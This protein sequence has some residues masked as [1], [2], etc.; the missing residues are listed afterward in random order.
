MVFSK[1][2]EK[3]INAFAK[4]TKKWRDLKSLENLRH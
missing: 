2:N 1:I 3:H 4:I